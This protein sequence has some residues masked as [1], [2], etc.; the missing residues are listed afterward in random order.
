MKEMISSSDMRLWLIQRGTFKDTADADI[1]GIDSLI[2]YHYMGSAEFEFGALR[3]ALTHF[4]SHYSDIVALEIPL[5]DLETNGITMFCLKD[6]KV[7]AEATIV[8]CGTDPHPSLQ[9]RCNLWDYLTGGSFDSWSDNTDFWWA[10]NRRDSYPQTEQTQWMACPSYQ[11]RRLAL[12]LK[13][14]HTK[15]NTLPIENIID[16]VTPVTEHIKPCIQ[17]IRDPN[18]GRR[19]RRYIVTDEVGTVHNINTRII[20]SVE[21]VADA[22]IVKSKRLTF[23]VKCSG[24]RLN[25]FATNMEKVSIGSQF[26]RLTSQTITQK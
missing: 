4:V 16:I 1:K 18:E 17:V 14:S 13:H 25:W 15:T 24:H 2:S 3:H 20:T 7:D 10:L 6:Q 11:A 5:F 19:E 21:K 12:A 23:V 8:A 9:E 22:V 26:Y